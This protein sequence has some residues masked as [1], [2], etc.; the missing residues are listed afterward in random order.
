L[1]KKQSSGFLVFV[2]GFFGVFWFFG[3]VLLYICPEERVL[4][5]LTNEKRGGLTMVSFDRSRGNFH[6]NWCRPH[7]G[8]S[9]KLLR[10]PCFYYLQAIIVFQYR[11]S[12]GLRHTFHIIHLIEITVLYILPDV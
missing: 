9:I 3:G 2:F 4:K 8:R 1:K 7:P 11:H 10:E 12:V 6:T 5:V